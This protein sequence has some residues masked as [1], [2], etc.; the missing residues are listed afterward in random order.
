MNKVINIE[1]MTINRN[2][3]EDEVSVEGYVVMSVDKSW[4]ENTDYRY[5]QLHIF[6]EDVTDVQAWDIGGHEFFLTEKEVEEAKELLG[7]RALEN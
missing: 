4:G 7:T 3:I 1:Q 2:G 5:G 6:V